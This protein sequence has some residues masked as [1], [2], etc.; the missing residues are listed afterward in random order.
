MKFYLYF[1]KLNFIVLKS[2]KYKYFM[3]VLKVLTRIILYVIY[4]FVY[5][6]LY[7]LPYIC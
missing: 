6:T 1:N 7:Q 4:M 5:L 2:D 3:P